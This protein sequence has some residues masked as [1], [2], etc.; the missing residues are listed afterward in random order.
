V[1]PG[2]RLYK[3]PSFYSFECRLSPDLHFWDAGAV[4]GVAAANND[5]IYAFDVMNEP[6]WCI[7]P[8]TLKVGR[9]SA[10]NPS[11][12]WADRR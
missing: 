7:A 6:W 5:V 11:K 2:G 1:I 9:Q 12:P 4:A 3:R 10:A 8:F